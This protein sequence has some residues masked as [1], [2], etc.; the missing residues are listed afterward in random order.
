MQKYIKNESSENEVRKTKNISLKETE[1]KRRLEKD[2]KKGNPPGSE[3]E[4]LKESMSQP[5][6]TNG[7]ESH[8]MEHTRANCAFGSDLTLGR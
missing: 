3:K 5:Q 1:F 2:D 8:V 4:A 7:P 6:A